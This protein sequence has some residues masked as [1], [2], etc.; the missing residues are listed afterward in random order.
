MFIRQFADGSA[1][2]SNYING[3]W[4]VVGGEIDWGFVNYVYNNNPSLY[5]YFS[6]LEYIYANKEGDI[7]DIRHLAATAT[8][9]IY[10][11]DLLDAKYFSY[12]PYDEWYDIPTNL[13]IEFK[14]ATTVVKTEM[15]EYHSII[16]EVGQEIYK[17]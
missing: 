3:N 1:N 6:S 4:P 8:V 7:A 16:Q 15:L 5:N 12:L 2:K 11:T 13:Q 17:R 14:N 9:Y 10:E